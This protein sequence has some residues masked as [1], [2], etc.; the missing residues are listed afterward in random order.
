MAPL[1][2]EAARDMISAGGRG[3]LERGF[4]VARREPTPAL[5]EELYRRFIAYYFDNLCVE[6]RLYPGV[7]DALDRLDARRLQARDLHQQDGGAFGEAASRPRGRRALRDDLRPRH[8]PLVQARRAPPDDDDRARR[9]RSAPGRDG[10]RT[11][12]RTSPPRRPPAS[13]SSA[14]ASATRTGRS[15]S[16]ARTASSTISTRCLRPCRSCL[17]W[18]CAEATGFGPRPMFGSGMA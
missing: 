12:I 18:R 13:R 6:T 3:L 11:P 17:P 1:P 16:T 8:L 15:A 14:S 4:E 2:I 9:R 7:L 5:I 10:R